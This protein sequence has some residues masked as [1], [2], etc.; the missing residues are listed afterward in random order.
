MVEPNPIGPHIEGVYE[1]HLPVADLT[2]SIRFYRDVLGLKQSA[3]LPE[4][5][6][7][8][9]WIGPRETGMLGL[10]AAG[11]GPL[12]MTLHAA[13]RLPKARVLQACADLS[14]AGVQPLDFHGNPTTE[15]V[16]IGW[17]PALSVYFRDPDGHSLELIH[18]L[19]EPPA[20]AFGVQPY[21]LWR[22]RAGS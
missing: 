11:A 3:E 21:A 18:I 5:G 1:T 16:V 10:W 20:P 14:R 9:F 4:R 12:R 13:F 19:D 17:M 22:T 15:P 7:A 2:R 6:I 8:F